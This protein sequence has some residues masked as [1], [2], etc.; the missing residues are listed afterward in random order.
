MLIL[1]FILATLLFTGNTT[2]KPQECDPKGFKD[3]A[4]KSIQDGYTF[5]KSYSVDGLDGAKKEIKFSYIFTRNNNYTL[6]LEN[7]LPSSKNFYVVI[8]D[9]NNKPQASSFANSKYYSQLSY[10]CSATGM[11]HI[12][13]KFADKPYCGGA[14]LSF[15]R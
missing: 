6:N 7:G 11:Y 12:V 4:L 15:K 13:F 3:K 1:N 14:V 8:M 9:S 2:V 10:K 5:L